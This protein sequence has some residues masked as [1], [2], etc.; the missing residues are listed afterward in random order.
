MRQPRTNP[1][2]RR[3]QILEMA[4][5]LI[6]LQGYNSLTVQ[7]LARKCGLTNGGLLYYFGSKE[8][9]LVAILEENDRYASAVVHADLAREIAGQSDFSQRDVVRIFRAI[10]AYSVTQPELLRFYIVLQSEALNREHPAHEF[11]LRRQTM[12]LGQF[13]KIMAGHVEDPDA[14][15]RKLLALIEGLEHQWLRA[16]QEFDLKA[17]LYEALKLVLPWAQNFT[18][19]GET[20]LAT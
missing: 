6:G 17:E 5:R 4:T 1:A 8:Q 16:D 14:A 15:A 20:S 3:Q 7:D 2:V 12:V 19:T 9:L 18:E 13:A 10:M 11:F